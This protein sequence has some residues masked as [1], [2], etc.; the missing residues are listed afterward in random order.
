MT[1]KE[2]SEMLNNMID[3]L[4]TNLTEKRYQELKTAYIVEKV[5]GE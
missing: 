4:Y 2:A 1:N 5:K 3:C